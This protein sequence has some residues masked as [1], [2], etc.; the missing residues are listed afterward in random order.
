[1]R[2]DAIRQPLDSIFKTYLPEVKIPFKQNCHPDSDL[3]R[4]KD[5]LDVA[6]AKQAV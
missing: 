3:V 6:G 1:L 4:E 2:K 5:I